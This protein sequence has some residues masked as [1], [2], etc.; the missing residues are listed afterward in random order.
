MGNIYPS[1]VSDHQR[2]LI[3][4]MT[5]RVGN[6]LSSKGYRGLF[7]MDF[8]I[9]ASGECYPVDLNPRRQGGYFCV[10]MA[11]KKVN[12]IELELS[13][14]LGL[15][16]KDFNYSDFQCNYS[17]AHSKLSPY[18]SNV[19]IKNEVAE[20]DPVGPFKDIGSTFKAIYYPKDHTLIMGNPGFY[21]TTGR[22]YD[23]IK[24]KLHQETEKLISIN[25]ELYEG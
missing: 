25:Y 13:L 8:L 12:L 20:G 10:V 14:A 2:K 18:F 22:S 4:D 17:W 1:K 24:S 9:T 3:E 19:K 21:L 16:I 23:E 11:S 6:F 15:P 5:L 7:G